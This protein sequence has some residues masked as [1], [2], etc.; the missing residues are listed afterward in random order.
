VFAEAGDNG[1]G[2]AA[3]VQ[4]DTEL[5][6]SSVVTVLVGRN[7]GQSLFSGAFDNRYFTNV[8]TGFL[9]VCGKAATTE[10]PTLYRIGF[11]SSGVLNSTTDGSS[12][13]LANGNTECSPLTEIFNSPTNKDWLFLGVGNN[14]AGSG[15]GSA[16]CIMSFDI[17]GGFPSASAHA[18]AETNGTSG[19]V[20]DNVSTA[21]QASSI[22]F[23][24]LGNATCG[25]GI[26]GGGCAIKLTQAGLN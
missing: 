4:A 5:S 9:Y 17:T 8:S 2:N 1:S 22:Y 11:N 7:G 13:T 24:N 20:V 26:G 16:G 21:A 15:G 19:I 14:C 23:S 6:P 10:R 3:L 12:R 25:D 18:T